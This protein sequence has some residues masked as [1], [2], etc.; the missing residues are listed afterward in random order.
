MSSHEVAGAFHPEN[1]HLAWIAIKEALQPAEESRLIDAVHE[2]S[3]TLPSD[4]ESQFQLQ[5]LTEDGEPH[6]YSYSYVTEIMVKVGEALTEMTYRPYVH[7][8][9]VMTDR[10]LNGSIFA[11]LQAIEEVRQRRRSD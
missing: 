6:T 1:R 7:P 5:A 2:L 10:H 4:G 9:A 8:M 11:R 3:W